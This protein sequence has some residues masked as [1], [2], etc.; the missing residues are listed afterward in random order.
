VEPSPETRDLA[1]RSPRAVWGLACGIV[2]VVGAIPFVPLLEYVF[3]P[4][5]VVLGILG[6]RD[7][8]HGMRG[9]GLSAG[10]IVLGVL[11]IAYKMA[12]A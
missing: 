9:K 10:A 5:A 8:S 2:G 7:V 3:A 4:A 12:M 1:P 11:V 6:F